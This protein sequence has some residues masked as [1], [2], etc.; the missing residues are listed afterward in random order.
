MTTSPATSVPFDIPGQPEN[1]AGLPVT[2][3]TDV[4]ATARVQRGRS[5][6]L[7]TPQVEPAPGWADSWT[8]FDLDMRI[9]NRSINTISNRKTN[10]S[11]MARHAAADGITD[12]EQVTKTWLREYL[13]RQGEDRKGNGYTT[14]FQDLAAFWTWWAD[15]AERPNPMTKI[16]RPATVTTSVPVLTEEQLAAVLATC[17]G[18]G[19][20]AL[21]NRALILLL[22]DSGL[23]RFELSALDVDDVDL[24][25]RTVLVRHGKG[26]KPRI[27]VI[28]TET[29]VAIRN[30]LKVRPQ[31]AHATQPALFV[32][33]PGGRL[34]AT[35][36]SQLVSR[37]GKEAGVTG[38]HPH[39]FRHTWTH[40]LLE[41][42]MKEHD[43]CQLAGWST[44]KQLGRYGAS[45]AQ[46][47]AIAAGLRNSPADRM[48][49]H[50]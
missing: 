24:L 15:D 31:R 29:A 20:E 36:V 34:Q 39:M 38:L 9:K 27:S 2:A 50:A 28:G 48:R 21:R 4:P 19:F 14:L 17:S 23:R 47:R 8:G 44:T 30:Y 6:V 41:S 32:S 22:M 1:S 40:V 18:R 5:A 13:L 25:E 11:I 16:P 37:L 7:P 33:R 3:G 10:V 12:P 46:D 26:D 45:R 42:E 35:G 43:I 49:R